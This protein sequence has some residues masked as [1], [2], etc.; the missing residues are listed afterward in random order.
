MSAPA[1]AYF[2]SCVEQIN[3][4]KKTKALRTIYNEL[5]KN[6]SEVFT[7]GDYIVVV[8]AYADFS[9]LLVSLLFEPKD[10]SQRKFLKKVTINK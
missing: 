6:G 10:F 2:E 9:C 8:E 1:S 4:L 5:T 7:D 3:Q